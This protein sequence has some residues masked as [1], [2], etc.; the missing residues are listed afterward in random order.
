[1]EPDRRGVLKVDNA[2]TVWCFERAV[3]PGTNAHHIA[4]YLIPFILRPALFTYLY[5]GLKEHP[6][7]TPSAMQ[8]SLLV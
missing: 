5:L 7:I 6:K 2:R 4:R 3:Y 1:M 8:S